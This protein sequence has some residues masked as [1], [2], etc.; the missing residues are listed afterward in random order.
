MQSGALISLRID[1]IVIADDGSTDRTVDVAKLWSDRLP[2]HVVSLPKNMGKGAATKQGMRAITGE[3]ALIYDADGA[4]P[5]TELSRL[6]D[7]LQVARADIAI[8]SRVHSSAELPVDMTLHRRV[9]GRVYHALCAPLH[10]GIQDAAC[11]CKLFT[12]H[13]ARRIFYYVTINRFAYDIE[14]LALAHRL[15]F[16]VIEVPVQWRAVPMSKVRIVR[17]GVQMLLSVVHLYVRKYSG[18]LASDSE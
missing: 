7:A 9:I 4:T 1:R 11:G 15:G 18:S 16:Q 17:D 8:G 5:I 10:P 12:A 2:I 3:Y 6:F 13:A 14:M